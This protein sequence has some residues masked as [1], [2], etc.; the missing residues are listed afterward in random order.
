M[1]GVVQGGGAP[2]RYP[3]LPLPPLYCAMGNHST[4]VCLIAATS[5]RHSGDQVQSQRKEHLNTTFAEYAPFT[6]PPLFC[7]MGKKSILCAWS[8]LC[9][10][11]IVVIKFTKSRKLPRHLFYILRLQALPTTIKA[12]RSSRSSGCR[13]TCGRPPTPSTWCCCC[14][15]T[16]RCRERSASKRSH[17]LPSTT[18]K[19]GASSFLRVARGCG[20]HVKMILRPQ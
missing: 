7:A 18:Q 3:T 14:Q 2:S 4:F 16:R 17:P 8:P 13:W 19:M 11:G 9:R 12:G 1:V 6:F 15:R 5:G 20:V 10:D